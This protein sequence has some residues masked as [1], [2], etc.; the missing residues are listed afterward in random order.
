VWLLL[1]RASQTLHVQHVS[2]AVILIRV[3]LY[4]LQ[5]TDPAS[6]TQ[7][8]FC[9]AHTGTHCKMPKQHTNSH[10]KNSNQQPHLS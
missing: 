9:L 3:E 5:H 6:C 7:A 4:K 2:G 10:G 1:K 8:T